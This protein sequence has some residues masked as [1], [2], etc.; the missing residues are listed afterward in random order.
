MF[1]NVNIDS[2]RIKLG[3]PSFEL[4]HIHSL[5]NLP[6]FLRNTIAETLPF[7]SIGLND[8]YDQEVYYHLLNE[9]RGLCLAVRQSEKRMISG[10][11]AERIFQASG[12]QCDPQALCQDSSLIKK[13]YAIKIRF[14]HKNVENLIY[15]R[16]NCFECYPNYYNLF[17]CVSFPSLVCNE[18]TATATI[19]PEL[20]NH[21]KASLPTFTR[22]NKDLQVSRLR[23]QVAIYF[24]DNCFLGSKFGFRCQGEDVIIENPFVSLI[25]TSQ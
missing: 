17:S 18:S 4:I 19:L 10:V 2:E 16:I 1:L 20:F 11:Y 25:C 9:S 24:D 23:L 7:N 12:F 8:A 5:L 14:M 21:R 3:Q 13:V 15:A 22:L 6:F